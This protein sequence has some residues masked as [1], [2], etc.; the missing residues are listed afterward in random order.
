[1]ADNSDTSSSS[2]EHE[3]DI[4]VPGPSKGR[5]RVRNVS[6]WKKVKTKKLR[7]SGKEYVSRSNGKK[8][9]S[10]KVG[11]ACNDGCFDKVGRAAIQSIFENFWALESYD[12]QTAYL[13]K[14]MDSVPVKRRRVPLG[15]DPP[16]RSQTV[17]YSVVYEDKT[18]SVCKKGF[19]SIFQIGRKRVANVLKKLTIIG[20][21]VPDKR[22]VHEPATKIK[23]RKAE[24]VREHINL[25]PTISSHYARNK[26]P[27]KK[28]LGHEMTLN[29]VYD[30]YCEY[31]DEN[32]PDVEKTTLSYY[33]NVFNTEFNVGFAPAK[34]DTCNVCDDE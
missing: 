2:S 24:C 6:Q 11:P 31:M 32:E 27:G 13:Q 9:A 4:A 22:G 18:Y 21:P 28:Y 23:G 12:K 15:K 30:L 5:K 19:M 25:L 8:V 1:M 34:A 17:L 20:T 10:R 7:D 16:V 29:K 33:R 3:G 14:L 26:A